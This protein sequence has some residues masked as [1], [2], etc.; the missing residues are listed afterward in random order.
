MISET[1]PWETPKRSAITRPITSIGLVTARGIPWVAGFQ[2]PRRMGDGVMPVIMP[3][4][5]ALPASRKPAT[6]CL[7]GRF[8]Q[9]VSLPVR[10]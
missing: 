7:E 6:R 8:A 3:Q 5:P 9:R 2:E 10:R 4:A 1:V